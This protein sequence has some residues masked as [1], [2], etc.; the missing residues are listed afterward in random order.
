MLA[1]AVKAGE[2]IMFREVVQ[3]RPRGRNDQGKTL[4]EREHAH[5]A[6]HDNHPFL[7]LWRLMWRA[8]AS[9]L[10]CLAEGSA[11]SCLE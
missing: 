3:E 6:D 5:V 9:G 7:H 1:H 11:G 4:G 2:L 8:A 10:H